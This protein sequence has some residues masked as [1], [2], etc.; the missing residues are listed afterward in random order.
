[1]KFALKSSEVYTDNVITIIIN[2]FDLKFKNGT[3]I[4]KKE[5][6]ITMRAYNSWFVKKAIGINI[7]LI[8][9]RY[10]RTKRKNTLTNFKCKPMFRASG[11]H[12]YNKV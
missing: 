4:I 1:M 5:T 3:I 8:G 2:A 6:D 9:Y 10:F 12:K 11:T 7:K